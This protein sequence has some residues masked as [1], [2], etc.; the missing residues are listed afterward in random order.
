MTPDFELGQNDL[1]PPFP[2]QLLNTDGTA[3][4][5]TGKTVLFRVQTPGCAPRWIE[6]TG[7]IVDARGGYASHD[8]AP[9]ET[10]TPGICYVYAVVTAAGQEPRAYPVFPLGFWTVRVLP[11]I[12]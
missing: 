5:L 10:L 4:D 7:T 1:L 11:Q 3:A 12:R 2:R 6:S 8:W 9:A